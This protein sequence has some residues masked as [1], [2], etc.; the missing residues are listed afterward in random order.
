MQGLFPRAGSIAASALLLAPLAA[1][2]FNYTSFTGATGLNFVG[3]AALSGQLL[4][5]T[6]A[7]GFES[8]AAWHQT[9]QRVDKGFETTF[10]FR[11]VS[12]G[13]DGMAFVIQNDSDQVLGLCGGSQG[14]SRGNSACGQGANVDIQN[15][16]VVELDVWNNGEY[17]DPDNNHV[18]VHTMLDPSEELADHL[19]SIGTSSA[20]PVLNS[21]A[22]HTVKVTYDGTTLE[23]FVNDLANALIST[24]FD[25]GTLNL[26][27]GKAWVGFTGATGG[28]VEVH[29]VRSWEFKETADF[30]VSDTNT[31]SLTS[32]G[33]ANFT[34][35]AGQQWAGF[36]YLLMGSMAGS[37][38]GIPID[39]VHVLPLN[40]DGYW[41]QT[42]T[43][44]NTPPLG[45]SF[46]TLDGVGQATATFTIPPNTTQVLQ[47]VT[48][49]HAFVVIELIPG[50]L[51][52]APYVSE[53]VDVLFLP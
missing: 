53:A 31:L 24:P 17:T 37:S 23:V 35:S 48:V 40:A 6:Q 50:V 39:A 27:D 34:L 3:N 29:A 30:L 7:N 4:I 20:V 38:P 45:G 1:A 5:L 25:M 21:G 9:K 19:N 11:M 33:T 49:S 14:Y 36:P 13:A 2:D 12:G 15:S 10:Q 32:G 46:G 43:S 28:A 51:L 41:I 16:L 8:G 44:P 18:S 52:H 26:D 42:L 22:T 47:G